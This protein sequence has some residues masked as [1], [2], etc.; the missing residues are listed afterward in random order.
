MLARAKLNVATRGEVAQAYRMLL[1]EHGKP[2]TPTIYQQTIY[3]SSDIAESTRPG[4]SA[5]Q[6][7]REAAPAGQC[8]DQSQDTGTPPQQM[9]RFLP[10]G[11]AQG[12]FHV[13]PEAFDGRIGTLLRLGT[14]AMIT[15]FLT[16]VI[17]GGL[18]IYAELSQMLDS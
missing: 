2:V 1:A 4:H 7:G 13:L 11:S 18:A 9:D 3:G 10:N 12:Y 6:E 16:L 5:F 14:I 17:L 15:V 8:S